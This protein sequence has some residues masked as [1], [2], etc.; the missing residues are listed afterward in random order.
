MK[1]ALAVLSLL[2][3]ALAN[4]KSQT[5][6]T[7]RAKR[8]AIYAPPPEYPMAARQR[9]WVGSGVFACNL[10]PDGTVSSVD[11]LQSTGHGIL[12]QAGIWAFRQWRLRSGGS[13]VVKIP[14]RFTMGHGVRHRMAGAVISD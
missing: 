10:R 6:D 13:K 3:C 12:D 7:V 1:R 4:G 14:L 2:C 11:V 9:G 8:M 5:L